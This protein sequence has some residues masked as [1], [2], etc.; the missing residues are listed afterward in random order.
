MRYTLHTLTL[1]PRLVADQD[2]SER[3]RFSKQLT[4]VIY[5]AMRPRAQATREELLGLLWSGA[6]EHDARS[7]LRQV[8]YQIRQATDPGFVVGDEVLHLR[9]DDVS[10]DVEL[11][12]FHHAQ[13]RLDAALGLYE[14]DFLSNVAQAGAGEFEEWAEGLRQQL[15]AERRQ[16]LRA[17]IMRT[18]DRGSWSEGAQYAQLLIEADPGVLEPRVKLVE[19][20]ALSGDAIRAA[21]AAADARAFVESIEGSRLSPEVERALAHALAPVVPPIREAVEPLTRL[22]EMVGRAA[23]FRI[24]VDEWRSALEGRGKAALL[25]GEAGI[26]KTRL[27]HE[28]VG[29]LRRDR[30]LILRSACY[31]IE[32]SDPMAPFLDL[33]RS[34]PRAP[35]LG[36]A[37]PNC[38]A[39][40]GAFV[41]EIADRFGAAVAPRALP[42]APQALGTALLDAF[43]AIAEEV[44]LVLVVEDLH[45]ASPETVEF[46]HRL[47]RRAQSHHVLLLLTA[48]D[49]GDAP[50]TTESLRALTATGAV[51]EIPLGPLD[52]P[53]IEQVLSSI[54][55][56]PDAA[57]G[58]WLAAQVL[59]R[60]LG[61]PLYILEVLKSLHDSG[62]LAERGGRWIFAPTLGPDHGDLPVPE[63]AA[64]ILEFRLQTIG[65]R[66]SVV[67]AAMAVWGR[68]AR[69]DLLARLTG[70][71]AQEVERAIAALERRRL[72]VR[73]GGLPVVAHEALSAAA[74]RAAPGA[75]L[76]HLQE[77]AARLA[78]DAARGGRAGDWMAAARYAAL[79]GRT[80]RA[81][82]DLAQAA[83]A[84]ERSSGRGAGQDTLT[85]ALSTMPPDVRAQLQVS[86]Q[87]VLEGRW[88]A[89]R[90]LAERTS[91]PA[92]AR[93]VAAVVGTVLFVVAALAVPRFLRSHPRAGPLG[94]GYLTVSW[95]RPDVS[96][97][98]M[99]SLR[100]DT[101]L[102][103]ESLP[104]RL[105]PP[106]A[107]QGI[108][109][110][111]V[112]PGGHSALT[113]C[114]LPDVDPTAICIVDLTTGATR[115]LFAYE[116]D[117]QPH[118][119]LPDGADFVATGG[120]LIPGNGYGYAVLL[121]DSSGQLVRTIARDRFSY[122]VLAVSPAGDQIYALRTL[123]P[124]R[125]EV[126]MTLDGATRTV[127]W[128][129]GSSAAA[130]S[131]DGK[132]VACIRSGDHSLVLASIRTPENYAAVPFHY[133]VTSSPAWS[134]DSRYVAVGGLGHTP[135][136]YVLDATKLREP[137]L[138][139]P[140]DRDRTSLAWMPPGPVVHIV[141]I[142]VTPESLTVRAGQAFH[143]RAV[144]LDDSGHR[145]RRPPAI[146]WLAVDSNVVRL[147]APGDGVADRP[148]RAR[149]VAALGLTEADTVRIDVLPIPGKPLLHEN[150]DEGLDT[151]VWKPF[152][153]PAPRVVAGAGRHGTPGYNNNG[154]Y[155]HTSGIALRRRLSLAQG[156]TIE[157]WARV[158][159]RYPLWESAAVT[160]AS[161]AADSFALRQGDPRPA[162][163]FDVVLAQ[164]PNRHNAR[165][166]M[167]A[168]LDT[169]LGSSMTD[170]PSLLRDGAW[171]RYRLVIY[172]SGEVRWFADGREFVPP[173]RADVRVRAAWTLTLEGQSYRTLAMLDD[174]T[175]WEGV[176]LGSVEP[177]APRN[178]RMSGGRVRE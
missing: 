122:D 128:C 103:A 106:G 66:P 111:N 63:S 29:R 39:V 71:D 156:L 26:G 113:A 114:T 88:S 148:G 15:A 8:L 75:L 54:A 110:E 93:F 154:D 145:V 91:W 121:V 1:R 102:T 9:R 31:A 157:Y 73:E 4:L 53:E 79:A 127:D 6:P 51:R 48:R 27:T 174:V 86:L 42:V 33:L 173:G 169:N 97:G 176:V 96:Q 118:G 167:T 108:S 52:L 141:R 125:E 133:P 43:A 89:R 139:W 3:I 80:E 74:L 49:Y 5:L 65:D 146:R 130:W 38:L 16:V 70:L 34:A 143:L 159:T 168:D 50:G 155:S 162:R 161:G 7:S 151:A 100:L 172:P 129:H 2:G 171:H 28:L 59:Q 123:G 32:Q 158:P 135:G 68:G 84:V 109:P 41:P 77:R 147:V 115:P 82:V 144:G 142:G 166:Q 60:T 24:L 126:L 57:S 160:L 69:A 119:W 101:D 177:A 178:R 136:I 95:G 170:L 30:G 81:A 18:A 85:R 78:R 175:V 98:G 36:G 83:A 11:F 163:S 56:L 61:V 17:L 13:G 62:L 138:V 149:I 20:L 64:A 22:P 152:G 90:W 25:T 37:S 21:G 45:W 131:P 137:V 116:G 105:R 107:A 58:Q 46:A 92:R 19:L 94:G 124:R 140:L 164:T 72:V 23:E 112:S 35:G 10:F 153:H 134:P 47:A 67:L 55:E 87:R 150:F 165:S 14:A 104:P 99:V 44:P 12:R 120:Y 40:L 76:E 117:A 132:R